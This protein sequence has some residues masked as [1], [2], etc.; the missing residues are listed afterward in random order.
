MRGIISLSLSPSLFFSKIRGQKLREVLGALPQGVLQG[1]IRA[2][3]LPPCPQSSSSPHPHLV[4][5]AE[6]LPVEGGK[7]V[8]DVLRL[9]S[10]DLGVPRGDLDLLGEGHLVA[11]RG[12]GAGRHSRLA[13]EF[14]LP[15]PS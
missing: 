8:G 9:P 5:T 14:L 4:H 10:V 1:S 13:C 2:Y 11:Q 7:V 12:T 6:Q 3:A 15:P